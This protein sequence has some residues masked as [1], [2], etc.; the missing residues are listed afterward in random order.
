[1]LFAAFNHPSSSP[2]IDIDTAPLRVSVR[3]SLTVTKSAPAS[4]R[5]LE[6]D[7]RPHLLGQGLSDM[8]Q[9]SISRIGRHSVFFALSSEFLN[10][11]CSPESK[12]LKF[13]RAVDQIA[14]FRALRQCFNRFQQVVIRKR[15]RF[16]IRPQ[17]N[18]HH[19]VPI[20][21]IPAKKTAYIEQPFARLL[22]R[23]Y[24]AWNAEPSA[25]DVHSCAWVFLENNLAQVQIVFKQ[26]F[27]NSSGGQ[28]GFRFGRGAFGERMKLTNFANDFFGWMFHDSGAS[29]HNAAA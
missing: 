15:C 13:Y 12:I 9:L 5:A 3:V 20:L 8:N 24:V 6:V 22:Q 29:D 7:S 26:Q 19:A 11:R 17:A 4:A 16:H 10:S 18:K 23:N 21:A 2:S 25:T 28:S 27:L 1:M 14:G